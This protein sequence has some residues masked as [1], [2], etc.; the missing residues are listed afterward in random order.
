[1]ALQFGIVLIPCR[2]GIV[3]H[4]RSGQNGLPQ[5]VYRR[6]LFHIREHLLC[7][8]RTGHAH[9]APLVTPLYLLAVGLDKRPLRPLYLC[10]LFG[11]NPLHSVG[12][13]GED[14]QTARQLLAQIRK[15][16]LSPLFHGAQALY[17]LILKGVFFRCLISPFHRYPRGAGA[18][19][20][21]HAHACKFILLGSDIYLHALTLLHIDAL[22]HR[23]A[24]IFLHYALFHTVLLPPP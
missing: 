2:L 8:F 4:A 5:R 16:F 13:L 3:V 20:L 15:L 17:G 12:I 22:T 6:L 19:G 23:K 10:Y 14:M 9:Y 1:M 21:A 24:R 18:I 11:I 7:P